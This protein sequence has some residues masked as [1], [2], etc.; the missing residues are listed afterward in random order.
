MTITSS[1]KDT[2]IKHSDM[3]DETETMLV[4]A[5]SKTQ[6]VSVDDTE[7]AQTPAKAIVQSSMI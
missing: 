1:E 7:K 5:R 6:Q 2:K 3:K 4:I